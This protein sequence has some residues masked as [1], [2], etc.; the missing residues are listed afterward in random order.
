M[1]PKNNMLPKLCIIPLMLLCGSLTSSLEGGILPTPFEYALE[2]DK[3]IYQ[4]GETVY[5]THT[6][7]N[8]LDVSVDLEFRK[9]P[10]FDLWVLDYGETTWQAYTLFLTVVWT[11]T[12]EPGEILEFDYTWDMTDND[13]NPVL[14]GE[15]DMVGVNYG[16][17]NHVITN[18]TIVPEPATVILMGLAGIYGAFFL[19]RRH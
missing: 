6:I 1:K 9:A 7:T 2:T 14:P 11:R 4:L 10:G 5:A 8:T 19:N 12:F 16:D 15:Y 18:I 3:A 17:D 13:G